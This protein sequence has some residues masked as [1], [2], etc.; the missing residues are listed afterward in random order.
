MTACTHILQIVTNLK[1]STAYARSHGKCNS[2]IPYKEPLEVRFELRRNIPTTI[3]K[4]YQCV[5]WKEHIAW[6]GDASDC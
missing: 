4:G 6:K 3:C 2:M 1:K 5:V